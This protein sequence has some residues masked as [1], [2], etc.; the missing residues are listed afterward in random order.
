M[1]GNDLLADPAI[2][3]AGYVAGRKMQKSGMVGA[4]HEFENIDSR[5]GIGRES[6]AQIGIK[7][8]QAGAVNDQVETFLQIAGGWF[9]QS[10]TGLDDIAFNHLDLIA[11]EIREPVT[12]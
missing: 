1:V 11:Q 10:Q 12:V 3:L 6:V 8:R 5:I 9:A 4:A 7:V 2:P